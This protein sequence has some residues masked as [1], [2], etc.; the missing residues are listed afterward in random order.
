MIVSG[1]F[2]T[3]FLKRPGTIVVHLMEPIQPGLPRQQF[4][5]MLEARLEEGTRH[6][7]DEARTSREFRSDGGM[8]C[9]QPQ[10]GGTT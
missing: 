4:M 1:L 9:K 3:G 10:Q 2:W 7:L 6:V 5:A 8:D